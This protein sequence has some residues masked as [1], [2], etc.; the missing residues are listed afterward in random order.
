[1]NRIPSAILSAGAGTVF[2]LVMVF[3]LYLLFAGHNQPGGGFSGGMTAGAGLVL[4]YLTGGFAGLRQ[5]VRVRASTVLS[6]GLLLAMA[7]SLIPMA[8]GLEF[9]ESAVWEWDI[10]LIGSVKLVSVL[11]FDTGVYLVVVGLALILLEAMGDTSD[12]GDREER[13]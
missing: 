2:P 8:F 4:A 13:P 7:S 1:M 12:L 5:L 6:A 3:S 11:F 10:P 9:M